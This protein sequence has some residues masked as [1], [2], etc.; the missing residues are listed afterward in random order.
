MMVYVLLAVYTSA[1]AILKQYLTNHIVLTVHCVS[2]VQWKKLRESSNINELVGINYNAGIF[3][4]HI[5]VG[6]F[7]R[8]FKRCYPAVQSRTVHE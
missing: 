6:A 1:S 5:G 7:A 8:G 3:L 4:L 2:N